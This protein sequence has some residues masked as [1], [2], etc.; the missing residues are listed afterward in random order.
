MSLTIQTRHPRRN[1]CCMI[2]LLETT[3]VGAFRNIFDLLLTNTFANKAMS[4][5]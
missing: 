4:S 2:M 1:Q 3:Q 5:G